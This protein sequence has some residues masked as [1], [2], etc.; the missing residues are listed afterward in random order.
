MIQQPDG[1]RLEVIILSVVTTVFDL[2]G[3]TI[4]QA[5]SENGGQHCFLLG[6]SPLPV[7]EIHRHSPRDEGRQK[8]ATMASVASTPSGSSSGMDKYYSSKIGELNSVSHD[9]T[10]YLRACIDFEWGRLGAPS[11]S[12]II[13][14]YPTSAFC[15]LSLTILHFTSLE[16]SYYIFTLS[17]T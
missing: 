1:F 11:L 13:I 6:A 12:L 8:A 15:T 7:G 10:L 17:T 4:P 9:E 2:I 16:R 3:V 14:T 5:A